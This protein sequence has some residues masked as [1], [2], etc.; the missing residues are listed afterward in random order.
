MKLSSSSV[1][2]KATTSTTSTSYS[3][4]KTILSTKSTPTPM[5]SMPTARSGVT[6]GIDTMYCLSTRTGGGV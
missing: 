5:C 6:I 3:M 1:K 4:S 2:N